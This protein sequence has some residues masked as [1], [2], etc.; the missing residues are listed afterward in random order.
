MKTHPLP[1]YHCGRVPKNLRRHALTFERGT[2]PARR[3][4]ILAYDLL[5]SIPAKARA[6][7]GY[8]ERFVLGAIAFGHPRLTNSDAILSE[9]GRTFLR[10]FAKA[11]DVRSDAQNDIAAA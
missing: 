3:A 4:D 6:A 9:R 5:D 1:I 11:P 8:K 7:I 10:S 2:F